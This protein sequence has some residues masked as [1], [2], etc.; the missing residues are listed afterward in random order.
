MSIVKKHENDFVELN[1]L[2]ETCVDIEAAGSGEYR[3]NPNF[4]QGLK[5]H[6]DNMKAVQKKIESLR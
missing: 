4:D 5:Q 3:I 1:S 6:S 2:I